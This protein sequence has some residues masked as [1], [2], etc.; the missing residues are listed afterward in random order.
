MNDFWSYSINK[1][2]VGLRANL[3]YNYEQPYGLAGF[4]DDFSS[5]MIGYAS[6]RQLRVKNGILCNFQYS[7]S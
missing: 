6:F 4:I 7:L 5:R 1:L 3:W 2:A